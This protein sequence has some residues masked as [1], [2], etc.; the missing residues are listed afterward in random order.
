MAEPFFIGVAV[1][2]IL[3]IIV[4]IITLSVI[5]SQESCSSVEFKDLPNEYYVNEEWFSLSAKSAIYDK[6]EKVL[7]AYATKPLSISKQY[8]YHDDKENV[9]GYVSADV[10]AMGD[11]Y[12]I[13]HCSGKGATYRL[14]R[15][16]FTIIDV[17]YDLYKDGVQIA[18]TSKDIFFTCKPDVV[19]VDMSNKFLAYVGRDCIDSWF[20]DKWH[21]FNN[22]TDVENYVIGFIAYI[23][24]QK[25]NESK[26]STSS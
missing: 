23:T 22:S 25:E 17:Q 14:E 18:K 1:C 19:L 15:K 16:I 10:I 20:K 12:T 4:T 6:N 7:G 11:K 21:V 2:M 13:N 8:R 5:A 26:K 9:V 24:T 3:M